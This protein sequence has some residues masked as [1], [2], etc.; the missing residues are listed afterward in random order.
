ML[1]SVI[2]A[3]VCAVAVII[4]TLAGLGKFS[5]SS[6]ANNTLPPTPSPTVSQTPT[7]APS[8]PPTTASPAPA[9]AP[10]H[11][12]TL[13]PTASPAGASVTDTSSGQPTGAIAGGVAGAALVLLLV[14]AAMTVRNRRRKQRGAYERHDGEESVS[15]EPGNDD[16]RGGGGGSSGRRHKALP[17][18]TATPIYATGARPHTA[19]DDLEEQASARG[20]PP[21]PP[22]PPPRRGRGGEHE[23]DDGSED[24]EEE[25]DEDA[26]G[27][28]GDGD[29]D[30]RDAAGSVVLRAPG[31]PRKKHVQRALEILSQGVLATAIRTAAR[32]S[33]RSRRAL[34]GTADSDAG[35]ESD[36]SFA[37]S[38]MVR[39][40]AGR[41][42][43]AGRARASRRFTA[44]PTRGANP[45]TR[46]GANAYAAAFTDDDDGGSVSSAS[47][48]RSIASVGTRPRVDPAHAHQPFRRLPLSAAAAAYDILDN[49]ID[50]DEHGLPIA[51]DRDRHRAGRGGGGGGGIESPPPPPTVPPPGA[52]GLPR[53]PASVYANADECQVQAE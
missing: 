33:R 22:M 15:L 20:P 5:S 34:A 44:L 46:G 51:A 28:Y 50:L 21:L 37:Q 30:D 32:Q 9:P 53:A 16:E 4:G 31:A 6:D 38:E 1:W 45:R 17:D 27:A 23:R 52:D 29:V 10:T 40:A 43:R 26:F 42:G 36:T 19:A 35:C 49:P 24:D 25:E 7:V 11:A 14:A 3:C 18:T 8:A 39:T 13:V 47:R 2:V 41:A 48:P 12:P